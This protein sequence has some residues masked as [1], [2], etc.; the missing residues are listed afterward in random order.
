VPGGPVL[1]PN[2]HFHSKG[3][4]NS[5]AFLENVAVKAVL[6]KACPQTQEETTT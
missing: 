1:I 5:E 2:T 4:P 6:D 3:I